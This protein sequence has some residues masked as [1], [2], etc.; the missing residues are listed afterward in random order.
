MKHQILARA[1]PRNE[2]EWR[3]SASSSPSIEPPLLDPNDADHGHL[4]CRLSWIFSFAKAELTDP[5]NYS[6]A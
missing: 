4:R 2:Q 1:W 6:I 3:N 5:G